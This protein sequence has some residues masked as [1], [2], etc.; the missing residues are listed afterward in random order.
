MAKN[1][2]KDEDDIDPILAA[3]EWKNDMKRRGTLPRFRSTPTTHRGTESECQKS[4]YGHEPDWM[5]VSLKQQDGEVFIDVRCR[6][7]ERK[8]C[9]GS[10][11]SL[12][13]VVVW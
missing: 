6:H 11:R 13:S 3:D 12:A 2:D 1:R 9:V 8:G 7:C 4:D 10:L 5:T